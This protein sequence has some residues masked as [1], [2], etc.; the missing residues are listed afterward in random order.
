MNWKTRQ[1]DLEMLHLRLKKKCT[2]QELADRFDV[3]PEVA[4]RSIERA[5]INLELE[6]YALTKRRA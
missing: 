3:T 1:R 5:Q 6:E 4:R 2:N